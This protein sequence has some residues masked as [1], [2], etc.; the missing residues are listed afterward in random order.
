[1]A[2]FVEVVKWGVHPHSRHLCPRFGAVDLSLMENGAFVHSYQDPAVALCPD[3]L[4]TI[5]VSVHGS[6]WTMCPLLNLK[7]LPFCTT[8]LWLGSSS[9][10]VSCT[11]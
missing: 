8:G 11:L 9:V 3:H 4:R 7:E 2:V 5:K 1:M 10:E 6:E